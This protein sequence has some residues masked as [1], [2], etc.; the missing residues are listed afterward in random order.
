MAIHLR[1]ICLVARELAPAA[2]DLEG[3]FGLKPCH[4]DPAVGKYGLENTLWPVG[5][6]FLEVVAPIEANT[7][8]GRYLDRRGG[9]GG[10]MVICQVPTK[11]EQDAVRAR[12]AEQGVRAAHESDYG[13]WRL[14]QLHP[15]DMRATF[16]EVD[17]D[18]KAEME[19]NWEPAGGGG[20]ES[21]IRRD[22]ASDILAAEIQSD[23]PEALAAHW[24]AVAGLP[25]ERKDGAP[26]VALANAV[27]RFVKA[28]DG[29]GP[30]LGALDLKVENRAR[31]LR[32]AEARGARVSDGQVIVCGMRFNPIE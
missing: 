14:M 18:E 9:D 10:Y 5:T 19:G 2:K 32:E 7:A 28:E 6:K 20:W 30:G 31:L 12:A 13:K 4:V 29:R 15:G 16:F 23:D 17:W 26:V 25:V 1:Q 22:V 3:V 8:A 24:G 11:A 27:L 21:A